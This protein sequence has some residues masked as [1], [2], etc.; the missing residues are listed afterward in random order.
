ML[1][2]E[3]LWSRF[4]LRNLASVSFGGWVLDQYL[5]RGS[6]DFLHPLSES[7]KRGSQEPERR[8][9]D[10]TE[11]LDFGCDGHGRHLADARS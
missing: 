9:R 7:V 11:H 2:D 10:L 1:Y 3:Y 8:S 4:A 5:D 6:V